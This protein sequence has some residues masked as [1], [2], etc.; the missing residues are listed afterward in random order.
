MPASSRASASA[1]DGASSSAIVAGT[2]NGYHVLKIVGYSLTKAVPNG[3]SIKSRPFRAGGHTWHVAYYPNGQNAEKAEYMAFFLCLDDTASKGVEAKAIFSLL[4]MEG[5]SVS[6]HSFTTRVVNFSEERSWGY[7]EFMK[8][9]SLEKSEYLKD[10]CFKIRI[11]VSVIADFHEEETPLIVVPPSDMHRQFAR[12]PVFRVQFYG[13]MRE[14]TT[15][16]A[17]KI[18]DM[19]VEVFAAMLTFI[20]TDALPEMKQ[21]EEAA[22]AQHLLVAA[23]RYNLERMKL[24]CEDKLSKHIDAGSVA[25]ILALAEQHSCHTLKEAC[26]EFLR[27]SRSLKAVVETDGFRYL[28]GSCPG[29]IKDIFSKLSPR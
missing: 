25:N 17:I 22:M 10:D 26:L 23:D 27:S 24:I 28:I 15:K 1:S 2:V 6:S 3:K 9:G 14:S 13:R 5:N 4:D 21:Q 12:S 19:E 16:R 8:R 7:S 20:Y 11:D 29:L 18:D